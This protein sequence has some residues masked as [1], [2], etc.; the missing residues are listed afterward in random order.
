MF[1]RATGSAFGLDPNRTISEYV[2]DSW[3]SEKGFP[4]SSV[5][6]I[7]Q[8]ADGYL[9]IG[10][11]KGL[12]RFDGMNFRK[13]DQAIPSSVPIGP[14][15][16]LEADAHGNLWILLPST[17]LLRYHDGSFDFIQGDAEN[18]ITAMTRSPDGDLLI[19][20]LA[21]GTL[22]YDGERF[23]R[24][25]SAQALGT[26][27]SNADLNT[28]AAWSTGLRPHRLATPNASVISMTA[29]SDGKVWL[30]AEDGGLFDQS[31]EQTPHAV[32]E[33]VNTKVSSLLPLENSVLWIGTSRGVLR[34]SGIKLTSEGI[35]PSVLHA[36]VFSMIRDRDSNVWLGTAHGIVRLTAAGV[37]SIPESPFNDHRVTALFEDREG[38]IWIGGEQRIERLRDSVFVTYSLPGA[39][40][41]TPGALQIDGEGYTWI[42][43]IAGGL[44]WLKQR[45][46]E[47]FDEKTTGSIN[48]AGLAHDVVYSIAA[49]GEDD[50]WIG[51]QRGGL[52]HLSHIHNSVIARTYTQADGLAQNSVYAVHKS[53]DG[54][55]W[56]GTLSGGLSEFRDGRFTNFT[57][58]D[59]L[60]SNT[61]S[62]IAEQP[63]GRVWF[64][65][66][67]GLSELSPSGWHTFTT[68]DGL[69]SQDVLSVSAGSSGVLWIGTSDGLAWLSDGKISVPG[70]RPDSLKEP[71][72]GLAEDRK[73]DLWVTT[74]NHVLLIKR[75]GFM[76]RMLNEANV[77]EFGVT[78]GL[79]GT[80]GVK[81]FSSV[82][83]GPAGQ[84]WLSTNRGVSV[85]N[86]ARGTF[87]SLPALL[88]V[89]GVSADGIAFD[90]RKPIR[91][92]PSKER[93]TF[94]FVGLSLTN[95]DR[96][97]YRYRLDGFDHAW[98]DAVTNGEAT[99]G[100]LP[101]GSY[102]FRV[103]AC[104]S[105]G[106]WNSAEATIG[107]E[108]EPALWQT[109][110]FR[111]ACV[112]VAG[113]AILIAYRLRLRRLTQ[114][115]NVRFEERLAERTR[116]AQE[117]HDTLL[118]S[119]LSVSMQVHVAVDQLPE[120]SPAQKTMSRVLELMGPVIEEGRNT[121]RGLR[122]S[123]EDAEDLTKSLTQI[124]LE[125]GQ[126]AAEFRVVVLGTPL[127]LRPAVR[128]DVYRIGREALVNAFRHSGA[129]DIVLE[130]EYAPDYLYLSVQD[131]GRGIDAKIL[132]SGYDSHGLAVMRERAKRIGGRL[133]VLS[134]NG[135][136][137]IVE[138]RLTAD[139][140]W[141]PRRK[142]PAV[143]GLARWPWRSE[144]P[145]ESGSEERVEK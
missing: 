139:I 110:W 78:D 48:A 27:G 102:R 113:L 68:R 44:R 130:I 112:L 59:G 86:S 6:T 81:R 19:S 119:L 21:I 56:A 136:G 116:I 97:R 34:W 131:N 87:D 124:P 118:Q 39:P 3:G 123:I 90:T 121:I 137:T 25:T 64:G 138:F 35:P 33:L 129:D 134:R 82:I 83:A 92:P 10:T 5:S 11:D 140:A 50:L 7:A 22:R 72:F 13:F 125:V 127:P 143:F 61:I 31:N 69:P 120:D 109:W 108:I 93:T 15:Q 24:W 73:G 41:E 8:T 94:R 135:D 65:T 103:I 132:G 20:S 88:H 4:S 115:L 2:H 12:L 26:A 36:E 30:G 75:S 126:Q 43:P 76:S 18:G 77:R 80:E 54:A 145:I 104:N 53:R 52:T 91:I 42:A 63:D 60:A 45:S 58:V 17:K 14:V 117:L 106:L 100:N 105:D 23:V 46:N 84:I 40:P 71:I 111:L 85:A 142:P 101:P 66:P 122:S 96:V 144:D 49:D 128:D 98:S 89:E 95:P 70:D 133:R 107:F 79:L 74:A 99:Y 9:W 57:V 29:T 37:S 28:G 32:G 1:A 141:G 47:E 114:L 55:I 51:R 67:D 62:S 38:N 16:K